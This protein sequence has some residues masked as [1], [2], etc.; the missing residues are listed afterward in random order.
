MNI[1]I[2]GGSGFLGQRLAARLLSGGHLVTAV[3]RG[4]RPAGLAVPV[5]Y[6]QAT[7]DDAQA[8]E[9]VLREADYLLHLAWDTTPGTSQLQPVLEASVNLMPTVRLLEQLQRQSHCALLFVSSGGAVYSGAV[10]CPWSEQA[11]LGPSSYYGAA[12]LGAEQMLRAYHAQT[13][14]TVLIVRPSNIYGP[15]QRLKRQFG[16]IP[17]IMQCLRDGQPF[18]VW[19]D[20]N[21]V[22]DYLYVDD[23]EEFVMALLGNSW[24]RPAFEIFNAGSGHGATV[25]ELCSLLETVTGASLARC[26]RDMRAVD[27]RNVLLDSRKA[28][29]RLGW[30]ATTS[31]EA[32]VRATWD[33]FVTQP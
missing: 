17:T 22:R 13:G 21:A 7:M 29:Q 28:A 5:H 11:G 12:K 23:F 15:G 16:V 1:V 3:A 20:G 26:Y 18:E 9:P 14:N 10:E 24:R 30:Q 2:L 32:G 27:R 4:T 6:L 33:W 8:L 25:N 19:G 31:L